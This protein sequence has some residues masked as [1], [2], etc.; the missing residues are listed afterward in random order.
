[1]TNEVNQDEGSI[2]ERIKESP[3]TV[4]AVIIILIV[5][6]A[7]YA[8]SGDDLNTPSIE[9]TEQPSE[10]NISNKEVAGSTNENSMAEII[11]PEPEKTAEGFM[12][13]AQPGEGLTHLARRATTKWL[14]ENKSDYDVTDEHR[15]Y[16]E[17][18][19]QKK[20]GN[21]LMQIGQTETVTFDLINEAIA[22]ASELNESQLQNLSQYTYVLH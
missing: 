16:I 18:Y 15:I 7:I 20:L 21:G 5:A 12:E 6:A 3:R 22:S 2:V 19:M 1:M 14:S 8:F 4:S 13:V 11:L 17:D 9:E 10:E